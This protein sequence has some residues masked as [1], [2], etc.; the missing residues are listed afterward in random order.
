MNVRYRTYVNKPLFHV[1]QS[2]RLPI[3][4]KLPRTRIVLALPKRVIL[5]IYQSNIRNRLL[6]ILQTNDFELLSVA[7]E[8]V[9]LPRSFI[10]SNPNEIPRYCYF[11][12]SGMGSIVAMSGYGERAEVGLF[13]RDGM[14]PTALVMEAQSVPFQIFMQVAGDGY[15]IES[16]HLYDAI[17]ASMSLRRHLLRYAQAMAVQ[18]AFTALSNAIHTIDERLARWI[19]MC[20]DRTEGDEIALT[21]EFLAIMLAVRRSSVTTSLHV[22]EGNRLI[23]TERGVI[24]V[25]NRAAL[26]AFAQDAYGPSEREYERLM[27]RRN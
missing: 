7:L 15:R 21:H 17:Q 12:E 22:L 24:T 1:N 9:I 3:L 20:H 8:F 19:L 6:A 13:G 11:V 25:R 18:T 26:E 14:T 27:V 4:V 16:T 2:G 5:P 23:A 10:L